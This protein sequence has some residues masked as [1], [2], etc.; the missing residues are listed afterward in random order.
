[1]KI[2]EPKPLAVVMGR[3][4]ATR[5]T[6][7]RGAGLVGCDVVI[8]HTDRLTYENRLMK[9]D[10]C[11]KY[12]IEYRY[13]P[14]SD[15]TLLVNTILEYC[16]NKRK[17]VLLP[18]DDWVAS[19]LDKHFDILSKYCLVPNIHQTQGLILKLMDKYNQKAI[20]R[21]IGLN[22]AKGWLCSIV[23][24]EYQ[25]PKDV[26]YPCFIKPQESY[27]GHLKSFLKKCDS[28]KEMKALLNRVIKVN[29]KPILIEEYIG[30]TKEYGVQGATFEGRAVV[31]AVVEKDSTRQGVTATGKI[32]PIKKIP[33]LQKHVN[34]FLEEIGMTGIF[35]MEFYESNGKLYFN[36]FNV[37]LGA[38]GFALTYGVANI[39]G[40]YVKYMLG[41]SDGIYNGPIDFLP[42]SFASEKVIR[43]LYYDREI[44]LKQYK[45]IIQNSDILCLKNNEDKK[46]YKEFSKVN[47]IL[48]MW[49]WIKSANKIM[50]R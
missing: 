35:D 33:E 46:P 11:S 25:I 47:H 43:D 5:L 20:A 3:L 30:I 31:P 36:E 26:T 48:P 29:P 15:D 7:T 9:I 19:V 40:L 4:Y 13:C 34:A 45:D 17:V 22:V 38:N 12:V 28:E 2:S 18:A 39:P 27:S 32:A 23:D 41:E 1:M 10:K 16:Q 6:L 37:R 8:I 21:R 44:T 50:K 49:R 24:G 42:K 14:Q